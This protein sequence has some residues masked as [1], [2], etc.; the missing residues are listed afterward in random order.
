MSKQ[1]EEQEKLLLE[2]LLDEA[3]QKEKSAVNRALWLTL[4]PIIV[5]LVWM[6]FSWQQVSKAYSKL[7]ELKQESHSL[8]QNLNRAKEDLAHIEQQKLKVL[9]TLDTLRGITD[10][11]KEKVIAEVDQIGPLS[12]EDRW[13][14]VAGAD[15]NIDEANYEVDFY[16]RKLNEK[17]VQLYKRKK[18][19][20]TVIGS[21]NTIEEAE[22]LKVRVLGLKR[23]TNAYIVKINSWCEA[24]TAQGK[25]IECSN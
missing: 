19:Y 18:F 10:I 20:R 16:K 15:K 6:F 8:E 17:N 14:I 5:G 24:P 13:G 25:I 12:K 22:K 11:E 4:V 7:D 2:K 9:E 21:F 23:H 3:K 1:D